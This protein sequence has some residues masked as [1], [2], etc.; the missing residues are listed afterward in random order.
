M[1]LNLEGGFYHGEKIK[2]VTKD[3][4]F[5][6]DGIYTTCDE[7]DPHYYFYSPK[8]KV[9]Q[10]EQI[11]A[12]WIWLNFGDVPVPIPLPFIVIPLQSGRRSGLITPVFGYSQTYGTY[13]QQ[14]WLLLC[15]K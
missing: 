9:I 10:K 1:I 14:I 4:Y 13:I 11:A 2:K 15:Y 8:M 3:T 7:P 6:E 5:I 12:E